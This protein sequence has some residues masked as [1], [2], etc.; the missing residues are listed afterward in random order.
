M[1]CGDLAYR[2]RTEPAAHSNNNSLL[3]PLSSW[4]VYSIDAAT[5]KLHTL[6]YQKESSNVSSGHT[7]FEFND[8]F[9]QTRLAV[10]HDPTETAPLQ[11][12]LVFMVLCKLSRKTN[13]TTC[14]MLTVNYLHAVNCKV[15]VCMA[16]LACYHSIVLKVTRWEAYYVLK[17]IDVPRVTCELTKR[18]FLIHSSLCFIIVVISCF[19]V[20][21]FVNCQLLMWFSHCV[22]TVFD[23]D[24]KLFLSST[25]ATA[26][27]FAMHQINMPTKPRNKTNINIIDL[28]Y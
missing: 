21:S 19:Q 17:G 16:S 4:P 12:F 14:L 18:P 10:W 22:M 11:K 28:C 20:N 3:Y 6:Q 13:I 1:S 8:Y 26:N 2:H 24:K 23:G 5:A 25:T 27:G 7:L 15:F 9:K